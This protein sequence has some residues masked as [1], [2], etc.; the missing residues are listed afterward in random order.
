MKT[1]R[2][3]IILV[4]VSLLLRLSSLLTFILNKKYINSFTFPTLLQSESFKKYYLK[5]PINNPEYNSITLSYCSGLLE[6][7]YFLVVLKTKGFSCDFNNL[8]TEL[9]IMNL[10]YIQSKALIADAEVSNIVLKRILDEEFLDRNG[11][12]QVDGPDKE[13]YFQYVYSQNHIIFI[14]NTYERINSAYYMYFTAELSRYPSIGDLLTERYIIDF[15]ANLLEDLSMG[16]RD[17][18]TYSLLKAIGIKLNH[19]KDLNKIPHGNHVSN[20]INLRIHYLE[21]LDNFEKCDLTNTCNDKYHIEDITKLV[22]MLV[23]SNGLIGEELIKEV[24]IHYKVL[25]MD[26]VSSVIKNL[27]TFQTSLLA[28]EFEKKANED[29]LS[30]LVEIIGVPVVLALKDRYRWVD[31]LCSLNHF[32]LNEIFLPE[33]LYLYVFMKISC[34]SQL[35]GNHRMRTQFERYV[36]ESYSVPQQEFILSIYQNWIDSFDNLVLASLAINKK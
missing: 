32:T 22:D 9:S 27:P 3:L 13:S 8:I 4:K 29:Y 35:Q 15:N 5:N 25:D 7:E 11:Y 12:L 36:T 6:L 34:L 26:K 23:L 16:E 14:L 17:Y 2:L 28:L 30:L 19:L 18:I 31:Y 21:N 33:E 20:F 10:K 1:R 24:I